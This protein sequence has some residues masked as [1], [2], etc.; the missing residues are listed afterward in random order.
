[1]AARATALR[2]AQDLVDKNNVRRAL[3]GAA[4][5]IG[6]AVLALLGCDDDAKKAEASGDLPRYVIATAVSDAETSNT[7]VKTVAKLDGQELDLSDAREFGGWSDM[8]VIGGWVFVSGGEE[9]IVQRFSVSKSGE[10]QEAGRIGFSDYGDYA[11]L[12][13]HVLI[14]PTKAYFATDTEYVIWNP[15]TLE[16]TGTLPYP[17]FPTR[18]NI[19]PFVAMDRGTILRGD[20]LYH[21]VSWTDTETYEMTG[22]SRVMI[23]DVK[24]DE[25]VDVIDV[26]CPDLNVATEDGDGNLY[27]SNWVYSPA[28]TLINDNAKACVAKI[29]KGKDAI[30]ADWTVTFADETD[31]HEGANVVFW[32]SGKAL[33]SVFR[34]AEN[35]L[36][37][38][39]DIF[40]WL[41]GKN[42]WDYASIDLKTQEVKTLPQLG[43]QGGGFYAYQLDEKLVLLSPQEDYAST[44]FVTVDKNGEATEVL[45]TDG[46]STRIYALDPSQLR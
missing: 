34:E 20:K 4:L 17:E 35:T 31:G 15:T 2:K 10:L 30:D 27:F 28:A 14:S 36:E 24:Q 7:Y 22:D 39:D 44:A 16:I 3:P 5:G 19:E 9:P 42:S 18:E 21:A 46:W 32:G 40:D 13:M 1:M 11:D 41:F 33:F 8:K 45:R 23:V 29:P 12:Y 25:I 26:P 6:A 38:M 43:T 37:D